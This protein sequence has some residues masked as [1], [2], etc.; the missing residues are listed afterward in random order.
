MAFNIL[1][2][3]FGN[4][5]QRH[6]E[7]IYKIRNLPINIYVLDKDKNKFNKYFKTK[8][9]SNNRIKIFELNS[10][11]K[12]FDIA[13]ISTTA[14]RRYELIKKLKKKYYIKSWIIEKI[15][16]QSAT[17]VKKI[18]YVL[19][20]NNQTFVNIPRREMPRFLKLKRNIKTKKNV[21]FNI[22]G[23]NWGMAGNLIHF[24]D[25]VMWLT[26]SKIKKIEKC[27]KLI[28]KKSRRRQ[29]F[30][31]VNGKIKVSFSKGNILK[32]ESNNTF[33]PLKIEINE[34]GNHWL[35]KE[36]KL[37]KKGKELYFE[38][39]SPNV[40]KNKKII[41]SNKIILQSNL[42]KKIIKSI[43]SSNTTNLPRIV[44]HIQTHVLML[45]FFSKN[46][47][48]KNNILKIT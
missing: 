28:W 6:F 41:F 17:R 34:N 22:S 44:D 10:K 4:I 7:S 35:L 45:N 38:H 31:E 32:I 13:I 16:E 14:N 43:L 40:Y 33:D 11:Q 27:D 25:L 8:K 26:N 46:L 3:G 2:C 39:C 18:S 24:I 1:I 20:D 29:G 47:K 15:L 19:K 12:K 21:Y 36:V 9:L 23:G 37:I 42:T 48:N 30:N 5:G